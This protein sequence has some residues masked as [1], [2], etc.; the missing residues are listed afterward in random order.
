MNRFAIF[1]FMLLGLVTASSHKPLQAQTLYLDN[2]TL[3]LGVGLDAGGG[4]TFLQNTTDG[5][6]LINIHDQGR[7]VQQS[8][9]SGPRPYDPY[10]NQS[11]SWSN[12]P[13]NPV[14][15]GDAYLNQSE[16][17]SYQTNANQIYVETRPLQWALNNVPTEATMESWYTLDG[18]VVKVRSRLNNQRSDTNQYSALSQEL[19]AVYTVGTLNNL[20]S[21][22]GNNPFTNDAVSELTKVPP[23]WT[24]W[25]GTE[26]WA[27]YVDDSDFGLGVHLPGAVRFIGGFAGTAGNGGPTDSNTGYI[28]PIRREI[29][30]HDIVYEFEYELIIGDLAEI[31]QHVY[32]QNPDPRPDY[33][34][35]QSR[36][37]WF[38]R[39]ADDQGVPDG[40]GW[41]INV[42]RTDPMVL[43]EKTAFRAE[44]VPKLYIEMATHVG[45]VDGGLLDANLF[46]EDSE[47]A[48]NIL[49]AF[50][51]DRRFDFSV[52]NDGMFHI[53][54][55]ELDTH[56]NWDGLITQLRL[57]PVGSGNNG[58]YVTLNS[59][60]LTNPIPE[61]ATVILLGIGVGTCLL[62]RCTPRHSRSR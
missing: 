38:L 50:S 24:Q 6:N 62:R 41:T 43:S 31:R 12:W 56:V 8:Y 27:A 2:G 60:S 10:D 45:D 59:I 25:N 46:W 21:Y 16:I 34:F 26:N 48:G 9:Y 39:N 61:P 7:M 23:P 30:D 54:E 33:D 11:P 5:R 18:N 42:D 52:I 49:G 40:S 36:S 15:A 53:Y 51:A 35:T 3:R 28:A 17:L 19:P 20:Y 44:D 4:I 57:D 14:Q 47:H 29:L 37:H 55:L 13:W 1:L 58:D 22:T 32:D